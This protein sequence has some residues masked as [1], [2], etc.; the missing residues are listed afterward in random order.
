[1]NGILRIVTDDIFLG[2]KLYRELI[3][4][5]S[6]VEV[7]PSASGAADV[8]LFDTR[9]HMPGADTPS[10]FYLTEDPD[11]FPKERTLP[12]PLPIG[13]AASVLESKKEIT[14]LVLSESE[15]ALR[16][17]GK[18]VKL[19]EVEYALLSALVQANGSFISRDALRN[20]VWGSQSSD[21][22]LNVYIHYLREKLENGGERVIL[23]S[24]KSGYAL[25]EKFT[26]R[27]SEC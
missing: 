21:G 1:M 2:Q 19:T 26:R 9:T 3:S 4:L 17:Y 11:G 13:L 24:R 23:S 20:A 12:L 6:R 22:L 15:R 25:A 7:A 8:F 5:F 27:D 18:T 10:V 16:L 14:P